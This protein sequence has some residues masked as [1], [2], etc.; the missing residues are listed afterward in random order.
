MDNSLMKVLSYA[1]LFC[2]STSALGADK[3]SGTG[4]NDIQMGPQGY[5]KAAQ[6]SAKVLNYLER[7]HKSDQTKVVILGRAGSD[8]PRKR[9]QRKVSQ[10]WNY[11]HAGLA[12]R[13]HPDGVWT[14]VH[15]LNDCAEKSS[16]YSQSVMKFFVD[17][18]FE[19]RVVIGTPSIELQDQLEKIIV[20]RNMATAL[21]NN[22]VYSSVSNP[23]NTQRQN[24]NEYILDTLV[25]AVAYVDGTTDIFTREQA[26]DYMLKNDLKKH[27]FAE[28]V[29][30]K[31]LESFGMALGFG[32]KNA[33][34]DDHPRN[35]RNKGNINM[36]SVGTLLEFLNNLG[37][38]KST[39]ELALRDISKAQDTNY[40]K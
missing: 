2:L 35:E 16:I 6:L 28:Q 38:L 7:K 34:L 17:D 21:F 15:L 1:L 24:S 14:I 25:L 5:Q 22:S 36:V 39:S 9:F 13:N 32:P 8:S 12:Y 27:V 26:K 18:P 10:Y 3:G 33:T 37:H 30:V 4:C 31:G 29:K 23:F 11:T 20:D 40:Q 19:Y